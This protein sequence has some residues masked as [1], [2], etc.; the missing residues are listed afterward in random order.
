MK[1]ISVW[2][3]RASM[4]ADGKKDFGYRSWPTKYRG[5]LLIHA[6]KTTRDCEKEEIAKLPFGAIIC[7]VDLVDCLEDG[8]TSFRWKLGNIVKFEPIPYRGQQGFFDVNI[9]VLEMVKP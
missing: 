7:K 2:Q 1:C 8:P 4:I 9:N 6:S 5:P 3:P